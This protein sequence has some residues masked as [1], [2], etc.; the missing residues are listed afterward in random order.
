MPRLKERPRAAGLAALVACVLIGCRAEPSTREF[1]LCE[2]I[3]F[4]PIAIEVTRLEIVSRN[5][6]HPNLVWTEPEDRA[7]ALHVRW[8]GA[9]SI[10][11]PRERARRVEVLLRDHL[12]LVDPDGDRYGALG[13]MTRDQFV[14]KDFRNLLSPDWVAIFHVPDVV[15]ELGVRIENPQGSRGGYRVGI[16]RP[17]PGGR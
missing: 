11:D 2:P 7:W 9:D 13:S 6:P 14:Y 16:I 5:R 3:E 8:Q 10:M 17:K 4:G 15:R 12:S 1:S